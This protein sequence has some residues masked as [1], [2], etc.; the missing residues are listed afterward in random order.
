MIIDNATKMNNESIISYLQSN[1]LTA[2]QHTLFK[3]DLIG[4][5]VDLLLVVKAVNCVY[6][7]SL[8]Q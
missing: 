8:R 2:D 1:S 5:S 3:A 4:T 6:Y 7:T